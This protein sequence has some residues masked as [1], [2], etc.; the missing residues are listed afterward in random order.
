[1]ARKFLY[2]VAVL[3]VLALAAAFAYRFYG[4][5]LMRQFM[6]PSGE[7]ARWR[8]PIALPMPA[9]NVDRAARQARQSRFMDAEG[10]K[11]AASPEA[12]VFF[13]HPTSFLDTK[14]WNAPLDNQDANNRA[15]L[16]L[17]GQAS[18][19]NSVGAIWAP[20]YR[21]ATFGAFLTSKARC[22]KGARLRLSRRPRRVRPVRRRGRRPSDHPRRAQP[23]RAASLAAA[24]RSHRRQADREAGDRGLCRRLA[25][26]ASPPICPRWACPPAPAPTRPA[27][28]FR[29]RASPSPPIRR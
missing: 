10:Y 11:P 2:V 1:L 25:G 16:F 28:S 19:F 12:A 29:G 22:A 18:A 24:R 20:R 7:A 9:R 13:V 6:V 14:T 5:Q 17:R 4:V 3:I 26:L 21:Q 23:G 27:A 8:R 15:A